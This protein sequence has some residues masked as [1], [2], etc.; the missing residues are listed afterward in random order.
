MAPCWRAFPNVFNVST[1][2]RSAPRTPFNSSSLLRCL[3][4]LDV[5]D[6]GGSGAAFAEQLAHWVS[7]T[8][9]IALGAV[10]A[11]ANTTKPDSGAAPGAVDASLLETLLQARAVLIAPIFQRENPHPNHGPKLAH[12]PLPSPADTEGLAPAIAFEPYRRYYLAHQRNIDA[13][14]APWRARVRA[15][16]HKASSALQQLAALDAA[17]ETIL[18]ERESKLLAKIPALLQKRFVSL[19]QNQEPGAPTAPTDNAW[20]IRFGQDLQAVLV[21]HLDLRLQPTLGLLE[22]YQNENLTAI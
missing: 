8:D 7:F 22:A 10:Q 19:L 4:E 16:L 15:V 14:V 17:F 11:P 12:S 6:A 5:L 13:G 18:S 9:A 21:A 2:T 1:M 3:A 20:Q